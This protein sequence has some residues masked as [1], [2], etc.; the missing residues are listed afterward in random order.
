[1]L[2]VDITTNK[3][4]AFLANKL[5]Y[6]VVTVCTQQRGPPSTAGGFCAKFGGKTYVRKIYIF[7]TRTVE[8]V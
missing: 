3:P 8:P 1:M 4:R 5:G 6:R 2:N 7:P